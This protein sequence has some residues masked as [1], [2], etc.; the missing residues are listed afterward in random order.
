METGIVWYGI[1]AVLLF[2]FTRRFLRMRS[3]THYSPAE[4]EARQ[5]S[6][7][8]PLLLDVRTDA[9]RQSGSIRG[10]IHIPIGSLRSRIK[11]LEKYK[12][13]EIVCYCASG[14][15][16]ASA[17][18]LLKQHGFKAGNLRGG[19]GEWNFAHR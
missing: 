5:K 13:R 2:L 7:N 14:S 19:I 16:S 18:L 11:E 9:E 12:S 4:V 17:A 8:A 3:L 15:R 10:S 6:T 1:G